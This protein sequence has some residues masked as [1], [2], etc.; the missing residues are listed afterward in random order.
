MPHLQDLLDHIATTPMADTHEH[1]VEEDSRDSS[2]YSWQVRDFA[3]FLNQYPDSDLQSAGMKQSD[4]VRFNN[5]ETPTGEK[6]N[7]VK[8]HWPK[9]RHTG[10]GDLVRRSLRILFG[11]DDL[12]DSN[13]ASISEK[14]AAQ[15]KPGWYLPIVKEKAGIHH[16]QVNSLEGRLFMETLYPEWMLQDLSFLA[17]STQLDIPTIQRELDIIGK[18]IDIGSLNDLTTAID[19]IFEEYGPRAVAMKN[20][21]AYNRRLDFER[22]EKSEA[23]RVFEKY[24]TSGWSLAE[25]ER[26]PL[27][28]WLFHYCIDK[29]IEYKL[30]VKLHTGYYAGNSHM[31]LHRVGANPGDCA[32]LCLMHPDA[33]FVFMHSMYPHQDELIALTKHFPNAFADMCWSWI[34]NPEATVRFTREIIRA[35]PINKIF[36]FGGDH[37]QVELIPGH[38]EIA[39]HGLGLALKSLIADKWITIED[40][41]DIADRLLIGNAL[42]LYDVERCRQRNPPRARGGAGR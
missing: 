8:P 26:K 36:L 29:S 2:G 4:L 12:T 24:A 35:A 27:E 11:E 7:L 22:V 38:G 19:L 33:R 3:I 16:M 13:W 17:L 10:Y 32:E 30:P 23:S 25:S 41:R 5:P 37:L 42:A 40:A 14:V 20:Q 9:I 1:L 34:V 31:P 21:G 6:W 39:R 18:A 15:I 28:D